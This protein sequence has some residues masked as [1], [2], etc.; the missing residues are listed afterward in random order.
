M[1]RKGFILLFSFSLPP[2]IS[3]ISSV[4]SSFVKV[5]NKKYRCHPFWPVL[6]K[7]KKRV[8]F[9][10]KKVSPYNM[11]LQ[12]KISIYASDSVNIKALLD[13]YTIRL[14]WDR[15]FLYILSKKR[16]DIDGSKLANKD[17]LCHNKPP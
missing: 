7:K 9:I 8:Y 12:R 6:L 10:P 3:F 16:Q 15:R 1:A 13:S 4:S 5:Q 11:V 14:L 17:E 2:S